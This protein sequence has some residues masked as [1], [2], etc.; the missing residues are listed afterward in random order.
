MTYTIKFY[1]IFKRM[2]KS[3]LV[4]I[5]YL[6]VKKVQTISITRKHAMQRSR[7]V[8]S[9]FRFLFVMDDDG[10]AIQISCYSLRRHCIKCC[11]K[12]C[13]NMSHVSHTSFVT[14]FAPF[15]KM[16]SNYYTIQLYTLVLPK[17]YAMRTSVF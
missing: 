2:K 14:I 5:S 8:K 1:T 11:A 15:K 17:A 16:H 3:R 7:L 6:Q 12:W 10:C 4:I 13:Y 9:L